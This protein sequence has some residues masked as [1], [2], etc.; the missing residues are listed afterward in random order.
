MRVCVV[1]GAEGVGEPRSP[2]EP[3]CRDIKSIAIMI[4][5]R[6]YKHAHHGVFIAGASYIHYI[7]IQRIIR[8]GNHDKSYIKVGR[9]K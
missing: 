9:S 4:E 6:I 7:I 3:G 8:D 5:I 2:R 1:Q